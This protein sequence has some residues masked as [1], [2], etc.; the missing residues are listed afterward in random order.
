[1]PVELLDPAGLQQLQDPL[2]PVTRVLQPGQARHGQQL[3][4]RRDRPAHLPVRELV[5]QRVGDR[6]DELV[7]L[8]Q[9]DGVALRQHLHAGEDVEGEQRVVGDDD[10]GLL[11]RLPRLLAEAVDPVRALAAQA[12]PGADRHLPPGPVGDGERDLVAVPRRAFPR[13][14]A[15]PEDLRAQRRLRQ[16]I[17]GHIEQRAGLVLPG[18]RPAVHLL[19]AYV[20]AAPL[21]QRVRRRAAQH[22]R[23]RLHQPRQVLVDELRLQRLG[24]RGDDHPL[25]RRQRRDQIAQGLA[26]AGPR[27][28]QQ[29]LTG[30]QRSRNG[31][32]HLPLTG[33]LLRTRDGGQRGVQR[34][35]RLLRPDPR[36][37]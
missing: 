37:T 11:G 17:R 15:Q 34:R 30:S 13:P 5:G 22:G 29:V 6:R 9:H 12:L 27:L 7:G 4:G 8:V 14:L 10:V 31:P 26:G 23:E 21:G 35:Q 20:V 16:R 33:S 19:Q 2:E 18:P 32:H 25:A 28:H 36:H 1:M 3:G 24:R